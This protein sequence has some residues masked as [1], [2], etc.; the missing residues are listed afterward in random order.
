MGR[1]VCKDLHTRLRWKNPTVVAIHHVNAT[2]VCPMSLHTRAGRRGFTLI[3]LLVVIAIIAIL[4]GLLLPAVQ[5]VREAANRARCQNNLKQL[6][7]AVHNAHDT[8]GAIPPAS[9]TYG[10]AY[11]APAL[12]HLLP[13]IE[14]ANVWRAATVGGYVVPQW[15]SPSPSGGYLRQTR[16]PVYQCPS[17]PSLNNA[18]DWGNGDASYAVNFQVFGTAGNSYNWNGRTAIP[19]GLP[20]GTSQTILVA[21]KFARCDGSGLGGSWWLRGI[22]HDVTGTSPG[23]ADSYPGDR[24]SAVFGGGVGSDGTTWATGTGSKFLVQPMPFLASGG[25]CQKEFASSPHSG[26]MDACLGD[27]SVRFLSASLS[28][29]TWWTAVVPNDGLTLGSDW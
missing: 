20:D 2:E 29:S 21:E 28:G 6:G 24:L 19:A 26:G 7:L 22:Y 25:P 18:L 4:I 27:G 23:G 11:F 17:D 15:V 16:I 12:F 5:K 9:G 14:Q 3:E 1:D 8:N 10:G 13:Y